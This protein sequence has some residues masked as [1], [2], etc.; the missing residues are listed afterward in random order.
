MTKLTHHGSLCWIL[1]VDWLSLQGKSNYNRT[2]K[3]LIL[4]WVLEEYMNLQRI[5]LNKWE[6]LPSQQ[7]SKESHLHDQTHTLTVCAE[8][9]QL[10]E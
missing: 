6:S 2:T 9:Y 4:H 7:N 8:S 5:M 1:S 3:F 10:I